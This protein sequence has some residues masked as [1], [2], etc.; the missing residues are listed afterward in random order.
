MGLL[1][2]ALLPGW[3]WHF[4][5]YTLDVSVSGLFEW[6]LPSCFL[7]GPCMWLMDLLSGMPASLKESLVAPYPIF[8]HVIS[9]AL[10]FVSAF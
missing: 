3:E 5:C 6:S 10:R 8:T 1:E 2:C 7:S 4:G 9:L